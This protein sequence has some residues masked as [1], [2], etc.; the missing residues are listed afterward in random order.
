MNLHKLARKT[1]SMLHEMQQEIDIACV[2]AKGEKL[3]SLEHL[4]Y[5]LGLMRDELETTPLVFRD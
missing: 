1:D 4:R 2:T 5:R 3:A